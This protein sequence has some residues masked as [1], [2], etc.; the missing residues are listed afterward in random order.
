[1]KKGSSNSRNSAILDI[2]N[3]LNAKVIIYEPTLK[4]NT[5]SFTIESNLK[6]FKEKCDIILV[7][8]ISD[9]LSDVK[10]KVFTRDIYSR[11]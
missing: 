5:N 3:N 10:H 9:D 7:N 11:D 6:T 4:E 1:M 8:R 2:I